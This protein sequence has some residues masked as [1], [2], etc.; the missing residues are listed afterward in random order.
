MVRR[1]TKWAQTSVLTSMTGSLILRGSRSGAEV[2]N[3]HLSP[4]FIL[5]SIFEVPTQETA[6][7]WRVDG[8]LKAH[9]A[10]VDNRNIIRSLFPLPSSPSLALP[11]PPPPPTLVLYALHLVVA[12]LCSCVLFL[13]SFYPAAFPT[14]DFFRM[15]PRCSFL[16]AL[17]GAR[18]FGG[19]GA[20]A[21]LV[22]RLSVWSESLV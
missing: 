2:S 22:V 4:R 11:P 5:E 16:S 19:F 20:S 18:L 13:V 7:R 9:Q 12:P 6:E 1:H 21:M 17:V 8:S 14:R 3:A 15:C 10:T